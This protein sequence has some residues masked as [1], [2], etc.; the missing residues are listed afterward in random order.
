M[1]TKR[2]FLAQVWHS[3]QERFVVGYNR[4]T[5]IPLPATKRAD[6]KLVY[7]YPSP[8]D[9]PVPN[10][11]ATYHEREFDVSVSNRSDDN[12]TLFEGEE[13]D[14]EHL[15]KFGAGVHIPMP[16]WMRDLDQYNSVVDYNKRTGTIRI[17]K[18]PGAAFA[19]IVSLRAG[20]DSMAYFPKPEKGNP[21][22][23]AHQQIPP[24]PLPST[25]DCGTIPTGPF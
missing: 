23:P 18:H 21:W 14:E 2:G 13:K 22:G 5:Y 12:I 4:P 7:R 10:V 25:R 3:L 1:A 9:Q 16:M 6:G 8:A 24:T 15:V 19:E 20:G 11:P 17:G